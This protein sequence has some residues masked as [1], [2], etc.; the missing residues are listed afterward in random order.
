M[1]GKLFNAPSE[2]RRLALDLMSVNGLKEW[3]FAFNRAKQ[4]MGLCRHDQ[5]RI[6]LSIY[7]VMANDPASV[8]DCILHEIAH[9]LAGLKAGHGPNWKRVCRSIGAIPER[10]GDAKMPDGRWWAICPTCRRRYTRHRR[11]K[12]NLRYSC[13]DCGWEAGRLKFLRVDA[14]RKSGRGQ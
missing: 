7:F 2:V 13:R 14:Q 6:E 3:S 8:R 11:P 5:R 4:T 10:T 1:E 12:R 9:A